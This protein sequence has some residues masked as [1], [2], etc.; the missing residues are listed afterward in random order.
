MRETTKKRMAAILP[1]T[2][3][4]PGRW[5]K[6]NRDAIPLTLFDA[7]AVT[8]EDIN[9]W[10]VAVPGIDPASPR[11][12]AYVR[13]YDVAGKIERA[14]AAGKFERILDGREAHSLGVLPFK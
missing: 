10:L 6:S 2:N 13:G 11:A 8:Q 4:K 3:P 1:Y 5:P 9:R 12:A 7:P 14:K